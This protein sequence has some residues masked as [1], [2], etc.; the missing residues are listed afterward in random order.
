MIYYHLPFNVLFSFLGTSFVHVLDPF[1]IYKHLILYIVY[2]L[3]AF[4]ST[5]IKCSV[6]SNLPWAPY[7]LVFISM[8][9]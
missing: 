1:L 7:N 5:F 8:T 9:I 6:E 4:F 2:I 3:L